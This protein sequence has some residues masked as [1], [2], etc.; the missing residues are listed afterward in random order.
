MNARRLLGRGLLGATALAAITAAAPAAAQHIDN[1]VTFGD[2]YADD[3]N[4]F[5]LG[6][7]NP[8]ALQLDPTG[9]FSG[10][11]NYIDSLANILNVPVSNFAIGGAFGGSNN[12]TLC[13]DPFYA[14]GTSPLCGKGLQYEVDQ[15]LD[16]GT[17]DAA[18]PAGATT[19]SEHDLLTI[20][21]GG[22]DA[23]FFE[24]AGG[25]LALAPAAG[26]AAAAAASVQLDRLVAAGAPTISF[27]AGDTGRLPEVA[28]FPSQA[29][30]R[31]AYSAAFNGAMQTTL[32]GY[33][34]DGVMVHYL[35]LNLIGD[36]IIAD[37]AAYGLTSSGPC[38]PIPQCVTDSNYTNGFLFYLDGLHLTSA[39]FAIVARYVATQ[40]QAPLTLEATSELGLDTGRQFG[41]TLSSRVDLSS[42][43]DG[44]VAQGAHLFIVGDTFSR[45]VKADDTNDHFDVDGTGV[46]V[47]LSYGFP[48]GTVGIAGNYTRPKAKF[49]GDTARTESKTWQ[50]GG[51]AGYAIAGAFAQGYLGYG[52]DDHDLTR[53]GVIDSMT[54]DTDGN[55]WLAGAKAGYLMPLG[56]FRAGPVAAI[57]YVKA[58]V[59]GYTEQGDA[60]LTLNVDDVSAKSLTGS[61]GA[62]VRGDFDNSGIAVRPFLSAMVEKELSNG[63]RTIHFAQTSAPGIVNSWTVGDGSKGVYGRLS[64]GGSAAILNGVTLNA[65]ASTTVGRDGGNDLSAHVGLDIGF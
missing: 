19:F 54:A 57:D 8:Q 61:V 1:I 59:D 35:D 47:G 38:S 52:N 30:I 17:Q 51:F 4:A 22:N 43:R 40:L 9:R 10:G 16:V 12:G 62:E 36:R 20:S 37:P 13:F 58:K 29:Q 65:L 53:L 49:I 15:F 55:H 63:H 46:T 50:I 39:G 33:A 3:G 6:Y 27:L 28:P 7:A 18:F 23:R 31:S 44:E 14:P 41:R 48:N 11:T 25:T 32:A 26:T 34:A 60:A 56:A 42:P 45:D 5:Q 24:Q 2:S 21:I 64:G